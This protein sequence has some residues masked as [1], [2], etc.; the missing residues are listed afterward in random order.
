MNSPESNSETALFL[1]SL[2]ADTMKKNKSG[3][4]PIDLLHK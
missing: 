3:V 1:I 2:G 4:A